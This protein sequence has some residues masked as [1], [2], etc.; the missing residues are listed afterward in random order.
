[1]AEEDIKNMLIVGREMQV[2]DRHLPPEAAAECGAPGSGLPAHQRPSAVRF[3]AG[4]H[5]GGSHAFRLQRLR[6]RGRRD[7]RHSQR[8]PYAVLDGPATHRHRLIPCLRHL[9]AT[10][11]GDDVRAKIPSCSAS[12]F[13]I[14]AP[15]TGTTVS[16]RFS[17]AQGWHRVLPGDEAL[18]RIRGVCKGP[19][20]RRSYRSGPFQRIA[21]GVSTG[22]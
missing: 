13:D 14:Q 21:G 22:V 6:R 10:P 20:A 5:G 2:G 7:T 19:S 8:K 11:S 1:M 3:Q 17:V 9:H 16:Y 18:K 12:S 15:G 4:R